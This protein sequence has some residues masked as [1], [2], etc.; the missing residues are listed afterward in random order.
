MLENCQINNY[1]IVQQI[2]S[3]GH[4]FV[5]HVKHNISNK[6]FAMKF[7][8]KSNNNVHHKLIKDELLHLF[9]LNQSIL[10]VPSLNL[11]SLN[12]IPTNTNYY[13]EILLHS[14]VHSH[15]NI[16]TIQEI[17][18]G[19]TG[20]FIIMDYYP[21]DLFH[22]IV[23]NKTFINDGWLIKKVILQLCSAIQFCHAK[24]VYHCDIKPENILLDTKNNVYLCDFGLATTSPALT[25]NIPIGSSFY[26]APERILYLNDTATTTTLE[27]Y[28]ADIW[29]LG[30][31]LIN[32]SCIRNPW[33]R[34]NQITD[35]TFKYYL[36]DN[37]ILL[38]ILPISI[39]LYQ[40]LINVLQIDPLLRCELPVLMSMIKDCISFHRPTDN[41]NHSTPLVNVPPLTD[42]E[43]NRFIAVNEFDDDILDMNYLYDSL[44]NNDDDQSTLFN[45]TDQSKIT[46][47]NSNSRVDLS[48]TNT[49]FNS[50]NNSSQ[51]YDT[52]SSR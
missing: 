18:D 41:G 29:S 34:A 5:F 47:N 31:I 15:K 52:T 1:R 48:A 16:V 44:R 24:G 20:I 9:R 8:L 7:I 4:T 37:S 51:F 40:I 30:I 17:L 49:L 6:D 27:S 13:K 50:S 33:E 35:K 23:S 22:S 11:N 45:T 36:S 39:H 42:K 25:P 46:F 38:K 21:T 26:M 10:S 43:F 12:N 14:K 28:K 3:G 32:L 19:P 2:G